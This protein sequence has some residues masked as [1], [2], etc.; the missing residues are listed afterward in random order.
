MRVSASFHPP[1]PS[2]RPLLR[3][4]VA[5][6]AGYLLAFT[7]PYWLPR[8][9][10][11]VGDEIYRFTAREPWRGVLFFV[12]LA[13]LFALYLAAYRW[14]V[15]AGQTGTAAWAV[16]LWTLVFCLL[17]IPV[18]PVT[19][20]DIYGYVFQGR[21]VAVLGANPF[22]HLYRDFAADPFYF[23][24]TFHNLPATTG[25]GPLWIA[26]EAGLGWLARGRLLLNLFLL[27]GLAA[28]LHLLSAFLVWAVL[29]RM[30]P[31]KRLSGMLFYAWN[32]VL[33]YE[34][35]GN[36]HNDAAVAALALL[37]FFLLSRDQW[38]VAIPCLM[39]GALVK[40]VVVLWLPLVAV[41]LLAH[42]PD[43]ASRLRRAVAVAVLAL[44]PAVVAYAFFW[45]GS[46]TFRGL[47]A[48]SDIH[49]NSLPNLLIQI[50]W[51]LW[52]RAQGQIVEGVKLLTFLAFAPFY[53]WTLWGVWRAVPGPQPPSPQVGAESRRQGSWDS[54]MRPSFDVMAFYLF[55]VGLQFWPWYLT[56]LMV[57]AAL[58]V[59][60]AFSLRRLGM[61]LLCAM[62]PLLY[63]PFGWQWATGRLPAWGLAL[64]TSLPM[65]GLGLWLGLQSWR[66]RKIR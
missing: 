20:S 48:Q 57:P 37:G 34:L 39:A 7:L 56:W 25:Y 65:I 55:F 47:L 64:L 63:F 19:S 15:R 1:S 12:A 23:C 36:A 31:E 24:A 6:A 42:C 18:Q 29:G 14:S 59:E 5:S 27:K 13:A 17:L 16:G 22:A 33:L 26:V 32:P 9:D 4:G 35:A 3:L 50:L 8:Y 45:A 11:N 43:W 66:N 53:G 40:P 41:W 46:A 28:G 38:W 52:P 54:F 21:I 60:P 2:L 62:A 58:L 49:G 44:L 51:S 10:R 30:A 61:I